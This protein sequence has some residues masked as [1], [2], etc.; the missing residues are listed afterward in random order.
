MLGLSFAP[1]TINTK[2][3]VN[4]LAIIGAMDV[5][6]N[7]LK[8]LVEAPEIKTF[9][10]IDFVKG[11]IEGKDVCIAQCS[12]GKV[13]AALCTQLMIDKFSPDAVINIGIGCSLSD[14]VTIKNV[15][16][17]ND[18]C[19]YD[20]DSTGCGDPLG[21]ISGLGVIKIDTDTRLSDRL[22]ECAQ[23]CG[24]KV[25]RGTVASGDT[26]IADDALKAR[27]FKDFGAICGEMEGAAVG[28]VCYANSLPFAVLRTVSDGGDSNAHIDYPTFKKT[29]AEIS[30]AILV[31]FI[32]D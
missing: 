13:N 5:E 3:V 30:A 11:K 20:M 10:G 28:Q 18:V 26:F 27:V 16:I 8:E 9:A 22:F 21:F 6:V 17:A 4:M 23:T 29:A 24:G 2:K 32:K 1:V 31:S 19:Q 12:P 7:A 14:D 25:H 15:V